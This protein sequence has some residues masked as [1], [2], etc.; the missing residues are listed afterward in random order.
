M[1]S[2]LLLGLATPLLAQATD[3]SALRSEAQQLIPP[4]RQQLLQTVQAA[5][6]EGGP[7]KAVEA[8]RLLAP[9]IAERHSQSPW[10]IGRTALRLRNP[11][12]RPDAWERQV[13]EDFQRRAQ[14]GEPLGRMWQDAVVQGEYRYM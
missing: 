6:A 14:A 9:Q 12:N 7:G 11:D 4:F 1:R 10:Q 3:T 8:C 13:L 5:A 2:W